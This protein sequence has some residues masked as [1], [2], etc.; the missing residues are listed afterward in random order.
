M[1]EN[2]V[3]SNDYFELLDDVNKYHIRVLSK[4]FD[5]GKFNEVINS[6]PQFELTEF[7]ALKEELNSA[8]G[9]WVFIGKKRQR[10]EVRGTK[11]S[12]KAFVR[13]NFS[14]KEE[15]TWSKD[16]L[17]SAVI[18]IL[19][20]NDIIYGYSH[21]SIIENLKFREEFL[22]ASGSVPVRG[23]DAE[24]RYYELA[25]PEP[26]MGEYGNINYYEVKLIN[27]IKKNDWLGERIEPTEGIDGKDIY[28]MVIPAMK[29]SQKPLRYDK[30][31]IYEVTDDDGRITYI[32]ASQDGA[33]VY[34]KGIISVCNYLQIDGTVAFNTGNIDFDGH[35]GIAE[36]VEDNFSV[37]AEKDIQIMGQ[38][39]VGAIDYIE[40]KQGSVYI[41]GGIS[42]KNRAKIICEGDLY[43]K[44]AADCEIQCSGSVNIGYYLLNC[45]IK[46]KEVVLEAKN[47]KIIGGSIEAD[48]KIVAAELGSRAGIPTALK[49]N[50]YDRKEIKSQYD[51]V[52][53]I[54]EEYEKK[55]QSI[56]QMITVYKNIKEPNKEQQQKLNDME[57]AWDNFD[58]NKRRLLE[59][60]KRLRGMLTTKGEGEIRVLKHVHEKVVVILENVQMQAKPNTIGVSYYLKNGS[61]IEE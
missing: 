2:I 33:V 42:G 29:G 28:G 59:G 16:H 55:L 41:R 25:D 6:I 19:E 47:S 14:E 11:D 49:V 57:S 10:I 53:V 24:I 21:T 52:D 26:T 38:M 44:F 22:A 43:T 17:A 50:G 5:M 58:A 7:S 23:N 40:S 56:R 45:Q 12:M 51:Q 34:E 1:K 31:S 46:A 18:E 60:K 4:G 13:L 8:S 9:E 39:G 27:E 54:L 48:V 15:K 32:Y 61:I 36:T 3:L 30:K 37:V 20:E 35:V